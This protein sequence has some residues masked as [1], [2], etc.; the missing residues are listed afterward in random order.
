MSF[1]FDPFT[2]AAIVGLGVWMDW[3]LRRIQNGKK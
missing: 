2:L 3:R 1:M